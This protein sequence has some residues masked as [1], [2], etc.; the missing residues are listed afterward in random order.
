MMLAFDANAFPNK[1][2]SLL[3]YRDGRLIAVD[4]VNRPGEQTA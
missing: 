1:A 2:V 4:S 3:Y